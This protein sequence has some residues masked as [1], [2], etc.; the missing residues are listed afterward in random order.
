MDSRHL[1]R[2]QV[3]KLQAMLGPFQASSPASV[4]AGR[5]WSTRLTVSS[6]TIRPSPSASRA[7]GRGAIIAAWQLHPPTAGDFFCSNAVS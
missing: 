1:T 6:L 5:S 7:P 4:M 2:E 3:K